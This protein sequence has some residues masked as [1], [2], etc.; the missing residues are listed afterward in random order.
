MNHLTRFKMLSSAVLLCTLAGSGFLVSAS[1]RDA[2]KT[3]IGPGSSKNYPEAVLASKPVGYWRLDEARGPSAVDASTHHRAGKYVG[4]VVFEVP[5]AL[6]SMADHAVRFDGK[7]AYAELPADNAFSVPTSGKG[8]SVEVWMNPSTLEFKG[9]TKD[10]YVFWLGKGEAGQFE[11][12]FRFYSRNSTRPNRISAYVFNRAGGLG[13]GAFVEE[14]MKANEWM[15][16]VACFDPGT[17]ADAKAG[18]SIYKNGVLRGS[19][20]TQKGALYSS[21]D[22]V[23]EAGTA[24]VRL[25]TRNFTSFLAGS[26]DEVAIYP[27][28]LTPAEVLEHYRAAGK[29]PKERGAES[30]K[31]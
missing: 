26:L 13:T 16:L 28:V 15:H 17:K 30:S 12:A 31:R 5:G 4:P 6:K 14:P 9:E 29:S 10:P 3:P 11:W 27:R 25:G 8:L 1:A 19:P 20:A 18:V 2:S 23:P 21:F 22:I 24:P 7:S